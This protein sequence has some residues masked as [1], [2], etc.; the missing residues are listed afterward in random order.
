MDITS[1]EFNKMIERLQEREE[2][3]KRNNFFSN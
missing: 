2:K 3:T 1:V